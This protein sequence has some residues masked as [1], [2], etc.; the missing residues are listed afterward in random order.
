MRRRGITKAQVGSVL[1]RPDEV[2]TVGAHRVVAQA[3]DETGLLLR[4]F[5][6][7]NS[8]PPVVVTVY[9]TSKIA[10]YRGGR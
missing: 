2:R 1:E 6:A 8:T 4:V 5:V 9:R 3:L 10:K 7:V